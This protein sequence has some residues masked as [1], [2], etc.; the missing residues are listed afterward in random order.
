MRT[1]IFYSGRLLQIM[2]MIQVAYALHVGLETSDAREELK[3]LA[4]GALEF[5]LGTYMVKKTGT[6]A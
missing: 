2:A 1:W 5:I 4:L 6:P 3:L